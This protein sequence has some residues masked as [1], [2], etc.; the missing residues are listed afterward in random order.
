MLVELYGYLNLQVANPSCEVVHIPLVTTA[1]TLSTEVLDPLNAALLD[2]FLKGQHWL[3][4]FK[5]LLFKT[6][7]PSY[8][9]P[10]HHI[11]NPHIISCEIIQ[12]I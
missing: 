1:E 3:V 6:E 4:D 7:E 11:L 5:R 2:S 8:P 9:E 12:I 10:S